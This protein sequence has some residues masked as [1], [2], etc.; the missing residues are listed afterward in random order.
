MISIPE[1][2]GK[3]LIVSVWG[4]CHSLNQLLCL[5]GCDQDEPSLN[6]LLKSSARGS[7]NIL[8]SPTR[9]TWSKGRAVEGLVLFQSKRDAGQMKTTD[10]PTKVPNVE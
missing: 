7:V 8:D 2:S 6:H 1:N 4:M 3:I 9:T 10:A 5:E